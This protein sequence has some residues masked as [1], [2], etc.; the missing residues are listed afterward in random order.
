MR[1]RR[2]QRNTSEIRPDGVEVRSNETAGEAVVADSAP[3]GAIMDILGESSNE[4]DTNAFDDIGEHDST[5]EARR[6]RGG[7]DGIRI[8]SDGRPW[9]SA[10]LS[11]SGDWNSDVL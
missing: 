5:D 6:D 2:R 7:V 9:S 8:L 10:E 1:R 11:I 4:T 3:L